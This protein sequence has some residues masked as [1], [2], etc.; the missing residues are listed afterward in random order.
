MPG[1]PSRGEW[2]SVFRAYGE[3]QNEDD[4]QSSRH[5]ETV[6]TINSLMNQNKFYGLGVALVTPFNDA[7]SIDF[8]SL[9]EI[10]IHVSEHANF[11]VVLGTTGEATTLT[12]QEKKE[13]LDFVKNNN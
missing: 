6:F 11:L 13:V 1:R 8:N 9:R 10:L 12:K 5:N 4:Y 2:R 3:A 7:G